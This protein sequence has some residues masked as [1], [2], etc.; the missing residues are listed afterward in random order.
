V[1][2]DDL[3]RPPLDAGA[4]TAALVR[5]GSLWRAVEIHPTAAST[6]TLAASA[7][8]A[9]AGEGLVVV[10]EH[11]TD[12]RGRLA[13]EWVTPARA[14]L[15]FSFLLVPEDVPD[16]QWPWL[17]L[18]TGVAVAE[19]VRRTAAVS[20]DLKWPNDVLVGDAKVAG[21]LVE[22]IERHLGS[23][24]AVVG[25]GV[26]VST[27]RAEMAGIAATSLELEGASTLD[28][29]VLLRAVLRTFEALY[30]QWQVE[31]G[32]PTA[33]LLAA[34]TRRCATVGRRVRV[35][36]PSGEQMHGTA[37]GIDSAG[38]LVV[39]TALGVESVG[40]GDVVHV[41][42]VDPGPSP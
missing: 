19:A 41:R 11:Q 32:D 7:A 16:A 18:L 34:Y 26:N 25:I 17:P 8:A 22:R 35:D 33:G 36:L 12:G 42:A 40:A 24:A 20:C 1:S 21:I 15:T 5:E 9:G 31:R 10:A 37:T 3:S 27:S 23:P 4:L 13:R 6:S 38:R 28:R 39:R 30:G 29:S 2:Y 14:A